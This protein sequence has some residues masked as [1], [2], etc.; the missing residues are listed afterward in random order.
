MLFQNDI[1]PKV[2]ELIKA[3]AGLWPLVAALGFLIFITLFRNEI[4]MSL[5]RLSRFSLKRGN[6]EF[7]LEGKE[8][9]EEKSVSHGGDK[10]FE[11]Q[12]LGPEIKMSSLKQKLIVIGK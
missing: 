1:S 12:E 8:S 5:K 9:Q 3:I 7:S 10:P 4:K 11:P 6:T 2:I